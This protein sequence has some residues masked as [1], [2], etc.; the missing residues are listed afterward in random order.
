VSCAR[1]EENCVWGALEGFGAR[2][3]SAA[4]ERKKI[5]ASSTAAYK[6]L[7]TPGLLGESKLPPRAM[8]GRAPVQVNGAN[9]KQII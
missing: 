1:L 4:N 7:T 3:L 9:R 5:A 6:I 2:S 8:L